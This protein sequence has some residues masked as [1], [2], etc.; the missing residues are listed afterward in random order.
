MLQI[1]QMM[2]II[3]IIILQRRHFIIVHGL[4]FCFFATQNINTVTHQSCIAEWL[5]QTTS[6]P[7]AD[8]PNPPPWSFSHSPAPPPI[9][10]PDL[11]GRQRRGWKELQSC[12]LPASPSPP[13]LR[14]PHPPE[15]LP[16]HPS[17]ASFS[18]FLLLLLLPPPPPP[19]LRLTPADGYPRGAIF[20]R[21]DR[22]LPEL[23]PGPLK[24]S[25]RDAPRALSPHARSRILPPA[26][27][28]HGPQRGCSRPAEK[29]R[30]G[31]QTPSLPKKTLEVV[32]TRKA[33]RTKKD[34]S[35]TGLYWL[36]PR[37]AAR[38]LTFFTELRG[39][40]GS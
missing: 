5:S 22:A 25:T 31:L 20:R 36:N 8:L 2:V 37:G 3:I 11:K 14:A 18:S 19:Q 1:K 40:A 23:L 30:Q 7:N 10:L 38:L 26:D 39:N 29:T 34:S 6:A 15:G 13:A 32:P 28:P 21:R 33:T 16:T 12:P 24:Q 17:A 27:F 4:L 9:I 35:A